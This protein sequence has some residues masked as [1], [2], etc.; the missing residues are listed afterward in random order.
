MIRTDYDEEVTKL[1]RTIGLKPINLNS[2]T[3]LQK[4]GKR[5]FIINFC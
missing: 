5:K 3:P 1:L 4:T 2:V